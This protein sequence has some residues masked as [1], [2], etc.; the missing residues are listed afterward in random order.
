MLNLDGLLEELMSTTRERR[1]VDG[2]LDEICRDFEVLAIDYNRVAQLPG[3][4]ARRQ[5]TDIYES[6]KGLEQEIR[7]K[8]R[9]YEERD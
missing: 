2:E 9:H 1:L 5:K 7:R 6:L 8:L 3:D 4:D